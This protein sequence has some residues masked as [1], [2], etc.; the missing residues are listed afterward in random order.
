MPLK[1]YH[2]EIT[3]PQKLPPNY[4]KIV[5]K[6]P[7]DCHYI[8]PP[9]SHQFADRKLATLGSKIPTTLPKN[10]HQIVISNCYQIATIA[11]KNNHQK[12]TTKKCV[13]LPLI[14]TKKLPLNCQQFVT[15]VLRDCYQK[16]PSNNH[17][18]NIAAYQF[19]SKILPL[20][21]HQIDIT[22]LPKC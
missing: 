16:S 12:I 1:D 2:Q 8:L 3:L 22:L 6:L 21:W 20:N 11:T 9:D 13:T 19:A 18:L 4:R 15:K 10:F 14:T 5:T 7:L 17:Q